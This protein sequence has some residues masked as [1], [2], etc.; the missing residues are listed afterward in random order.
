[1]QT[2]YYCLFCKSRAGTLQ[3][4]SDNKCTALYQERTGEASKHHNQ[5]T[6]HLELGQRSYEG[7]GNGKVKNRCSKDNKASLEAW[8]EKRAG[9]HYR[10]RPQTV[11]HLLGSAASCRVSRVVELHEQALSRLPG[12]I[13]AAVVDDLGMLAADAHSGR[14]LAVQ[15]G[16][17]CSSYP[18]G[19]S[20]QGL[21]SLGAGRQRESAWKCSRRCIRPLS[22]L[23]QPGSHY[24][25]CQ[26][27]WAS[28]STAAI[29]SSW[30]STSALHEDGR[31][32]LHHGLQLTA[33]AVR[34]WGRGRS[35]PHV[36]GR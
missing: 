21:C 27:K 1:M 26:Q 30:E 6:T 8:M 15:I 3:P 36:G 2:P 12:P 16:A 22:T 25:A 4:L 9:G 34:L 7:S 13:D 24:R 10:R 5:R 35:Y 20:S 17:P 29:H 18:A 28:P 31:R 19:S 33:H 23:L 14:C 32:G 11:I